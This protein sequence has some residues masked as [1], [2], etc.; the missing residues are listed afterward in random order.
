MFIRMKRRNNLA[1]QNLGF[2]RRYLMWQAKSYNTSHHRH[3]R[4]SPINHC[5]SPGVVI[6]Q[7]TSFIICDVRTRRPIY[8]SKQDISVH[9]APDLDKLESVNAYVL[10]RLPVNQGTE[11][12]VRTGYILSHHLNTLQHLTVCKRT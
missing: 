8:Q 11:T 1:S 2:F 10:L 6:P 5:S 3:A 12:K 4:S 9:S 7:Q